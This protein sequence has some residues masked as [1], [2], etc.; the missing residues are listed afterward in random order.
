MVSLYVDPAFNGEL[1]SFSTTV[2]KRRR[3]VKHNVW[4]GSDSNHRRGKCWSSW[5]F[6]LSFVPHPFLLVC[7]TAGWFLI[8]FRILN[9]SVC[10]MLTFPSHS[11]LLLVSSFSFRWIFFNVAFILLR[12]LERTI[13][14]DVNW[15]HVSRLQ[16]TSQSAW[17]PSAGQGVG[18]E[19]VD[20]WTSLTRS[21]PSDLWSSAAYVVSLGGRRG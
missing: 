7:Q 20:D 1:R 13:S 17:W 14:T 4:I 18:K 11:F 16:Q 10:Y 21:W 5:F 3:A 2:E 6:V 19:W 9:F 8:S 15:F 12:L